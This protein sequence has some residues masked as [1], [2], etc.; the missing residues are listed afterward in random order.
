MARDKVETK[1]RVLV[2][3][4][5]SSYRMAPFAAAANKLGVEVVR[6]LDVPPAHVGAG[7]AVIG[8]DFRDPGRAVRYVR[9]FAQ[10]RPVHAVIPTDDATVS[11]AAHVAAALGLPHN[12]VAAA[13]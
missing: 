2:L 11:V 4:A 10:E 3:A 8:L 7:E 13:E 9:A 12:S 5:A 1:R 6:G